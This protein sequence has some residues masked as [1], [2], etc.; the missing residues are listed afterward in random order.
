MHPYDYSSA[1]PAPVFNLEAKTSHRSHY[2]GTLPDSCEKDNSI[3]GEIFIP[4]SS[5]RVPLIILVP[6]FG[7]D[8]AVPALLMGR[9]LVKLGMA[10]FTLY[11]VFHSRRRPPASGG[12][13]RMDTASECLDGFRSTVNDVRCMV[14][15]ATTSDN[16]D[17]GKIAIIGASMGGMISTIAMAL[18]P[19]I[20]AGIF[21][22]TGGNLEEMSWAGA[23][24]LPAIGHACTREECREVYSHYP[25]FL[26]EVTAKGL[27]DVTPAKECFLFD[28]LTFAP[29]LQGRPILMLSA[30]EDEIVPRIS[31]T[32][33]WEACGEPRIVWLATNH[34]G[35][36]MQQSVTEKEIA[37]FLKSVFQ[38]T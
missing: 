6:G 26:E 29:G 34:M 37:G 21:M 12:P 4:H 14:E 38:I 33:F 17:S 2:I 3:F 11:T 22:V 28:P 13:A 18:E 5:G 9:S 19:R 23:K 27:A 24:D 35:I 7:D 30:L 16:I 8:S 32:S 15:W 31:A 1:G 36:Y 20:A 10:A 25:T